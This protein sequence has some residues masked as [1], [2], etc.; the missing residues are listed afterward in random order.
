MEGE[1]Q[2]SMLRAGR[3]LNNHE[4]WH[5]M[6][7][8]PYHGAMPTRPLLIVCDDAGHPSVDR[9][10]REL[11]DRTRLPLSAEVMVE[12]PGAIASVQ[13]HLADHPQISL[14]LHVE[15]AGIS[16]AKRCALSHELA[17]QGSCL[18]EQPWVQA[19]AALDAARQLE[20]FRE[21]FGRDPAHVSTHGNFNVR[22]KTDV[23][24]W[25]H[26]LMDELFNGQPPPQQVVLPVVRHNLYSWNLP[27]TAREPLDALQFQAALKALPHA[28]AEFVLHP[29]RPQPE[30][31]ALDMLFDAAMRVRDLEAGVIILTSGAIEAAGWTV[32]AVTDLRPPAG[33]ASER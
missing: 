14:G 32:C 4:A 1:E 10:I 13:T 25:W 23:C 24:P 7:A 28:A 3:P 12:Q 17:T 30:D 8:V 27:G 26:A 20:I 22:Q 31:P 9:G 16:D 2:A 15:L 6:V 19:Q 5:L 29:A 21:A 18:A 11:A 33:R